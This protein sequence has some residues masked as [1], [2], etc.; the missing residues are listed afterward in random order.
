[1]LEMSAVRRDT[2]ATSIRETEDRS[3]A[4]GSCYDPFTYNMK[5]EDIYTIKKLR[6]AIMYRIH[7]IYKIIENILSIRFNI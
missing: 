2:N 6:D 1:M 4:K 7:I 3:S 5:T